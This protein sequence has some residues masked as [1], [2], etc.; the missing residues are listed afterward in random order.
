VGIAG[1]DPKEGIFQLDKAMLV[2]TGWPISILG[3]ELVGDRR[4]GRINKKRTAWMCAETYYLL[5]TQTSL[6]NFCMHLFSYG[7]SAGS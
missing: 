1:T 5:S 4:I 7:A 6:R 3:L 2:A